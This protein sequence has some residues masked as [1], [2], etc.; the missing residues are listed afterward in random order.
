MRYWPLDAY[1]KVTPIQMQDDTKRP[2]SLSS[3]S[4][5]ATMHLRQREVR[6]LHRRDT[7]HLPHLP[8]P[9]SLPSLPHARSYKSSSSSTS[10]ISKVDHRVVF[11]DHYH[12]P[13]VTPNNITYHHHNNSQLKNFNYE[14]TN[15][16]VI[17]TL[18]FYFY[19][20]FLYYFYKY[21]ITCNIFHR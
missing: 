9:P 8:A 3:S 7:R 17:E 1:V 20:S 19:S 12:K 2:S 16:N 11:I 5:N 21:Y 15:E 10:N 18:K 4:S 6:H 13:P 14:I